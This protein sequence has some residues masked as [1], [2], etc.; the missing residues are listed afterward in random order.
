MH[1]WELKDINIEAEGQK[2]HTLEEYQGSELAGVEAKVTKVTCARGG[3]K[4][5]FTESE[6]GKPAD[7]MVHPVHECKADEK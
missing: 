3:E 6:S 2:T 4:L 1:K 5:E 7:C